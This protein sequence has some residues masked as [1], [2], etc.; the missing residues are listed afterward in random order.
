[1]PDFADNDPDD[2]LIGRP[3]GLFFEAGLAADLAQKTRGRGAAISDFNFDSMLDIALVNQE[4]KKLC[5][6][7][8]EAAHKQTRLVL[9]GTTTPFD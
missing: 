5:G 7:T 3:N 2:L 8:K 6:E 1:M 4:G 9:C